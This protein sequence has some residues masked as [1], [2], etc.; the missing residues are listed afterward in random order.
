MIQTIR[1]GGKKSRTNIRGLGENVKQM[2]RGEG[3]KKHMSFKFRILM[4]YDVYF[5]N[6]ISS[7]NM[8][9][10]LKNFQTV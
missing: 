10:R 9:E 8:F 1:G 5:F 6:I 4:Q 2:I 7:N 3:K